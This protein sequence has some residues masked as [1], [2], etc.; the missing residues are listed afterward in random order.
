M[1]SDKKTF[2]IN[3]FCFLCHSSIAAPNFFKSSISASC[4]LTFRSNERISQ[5]FL[6]TPSFNGLLPGLEFMSLSTPLFLY[7]SI[8]LSSVGLEIFQLFANFVL[9]IPACPASFTIFNFC[10][11]VYLLLFKINIL[12]FSNILTYF[13]CKVN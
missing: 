6:L 11:A 8:H 12:S 4:F 5:Y 1:L 9:L 3:Y 13:D 7:C 2:L 10:S